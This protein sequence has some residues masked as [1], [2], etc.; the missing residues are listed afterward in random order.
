M[1]DE[2]R[3]QRG[4]ERWKEDG[5]ERGTKDEGWKEEG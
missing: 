4:G 1:T 2:R 3:K 5:E